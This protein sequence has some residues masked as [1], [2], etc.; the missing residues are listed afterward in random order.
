MKVI[1]TGGTGLIGSALSKSL[2]DD[3]HEVIVLS[4]SPMKAE[5][6]PPAVQ[7]VEWDARSA[8]GWGHLAAGADAIVNL[9][10]ESLA[11]GRW[12]DARKEKI[13]H[14]RLNAG[15]AVVEAVEAAETKPNVLIQSSAV[16]YYGPRNGQEIDEQAQAGDDFLAQICVEW[17]A[18]T[19]PVEEMGVR[20]VIARSGP[21]LS[22]ESGAL[23]RMLL[24]FKM[25]VG[26]PVGSGEQGFSWIHLAD[27]VAA[28]RF[29]I[30]NSAAS[31]PFNLSAPNP[32]TNAQFSQAL[33][34]ALHRPA[35]MPV[36]A[37]MLKLIYGEM[38]T[39]I[40]E[41]Q[42]AVPNRLTELGFTFQFPHVDGAL[43]DLV[44]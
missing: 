31:G 41:G 40:L 7:V 37:F 35:V 26:G 3:N 1:I 19:A 36:P 17:E 16:G 25:F 33:G 14:S 27:E 24:P 2:V 42:Q 39:V 10:G 20:R 13:R 23:P 28:I 32:V 8:K 15:R 18:A 44:G 4:R 22:T 21:V 30:E 9:A 6:L 29:L 11:E 38:A 12:T 34:K 43:E 5:N